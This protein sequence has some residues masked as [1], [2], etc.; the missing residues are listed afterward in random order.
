MPKPINP[1]NKYLD[2]SIQAAT[3]QFEEAIADTNS[4]LGEAIAS[5]NNRLTTELGV[6][7]TKLDNQQQLQEER[8]KKELAASNESLKMFIVEAL[9]AHGVTP[10]T[11]TAATSTPAAAATVTATTT[12]PAAT[13]IAATTVPAATVAPTQ[14][15]PTSGISL[16]SFT[17]PV[18]EPIFTQ[19]STPIHTT[20]FHSFS[21]GQQVS[22]FPTTPLSAPLQFPHHHGTYTPPVMTT[23]LYTLPPPPHPPPPFYTAG[24]TS[25]MFSSPQFQYSTPNQPLPSYP[26]FNTPPPP[27]Y[28][29]P[30]F[31]N[32][33][34]EMGTF[35][36]TDA[37]DWLFQAEQFFLFYNIAPENRLPMVA[38]YMKGEALGWYKWMFKNH[39]L[40]DWPSFS[41]ALELRFGPS[42]YENH[43]AQLFKLKQT[44]SVS[45]YQAIFEKL[46]NRV[47]GLPADAMLNC[48]ISGLNPEINNEIAIQKPYT[49]SQAICQSY[50]K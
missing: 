28:N 30:P 37:L 27:S 47:I 18:S 48:F 1:T 33:K 44:G 17:Q 2:D 49:I 20:T 32:P 38:F 40:T 35:D 12:I 29:H 14:P 6:L 34:I 39:E 13:V 50:E 8:F 26:H 31:R 10:T 42:T 5:T 23:S 19:L 21:R 15:S 41:R 22:I 36:G 45:E 4:R 9:K 7:H 46:G 3:Q 43:Q 25:P 16:S 11:T 24:S